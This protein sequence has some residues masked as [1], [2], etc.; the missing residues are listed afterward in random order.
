R[1]ARDEIAGSGGE[2]RS[3]VA[4]GPRSEGVTDPREQCQLA[5]AEQSQVSM[6]RSR[7]V[8]C[9]GS[10]ASLTAR[11]THARRTPNA[12]RRATLDS[13]TPPLANTAMLTAEGRAPPP[14]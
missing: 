8:A 7:R 5:I 1:A 11:I 13:S 14:P 9:S 2:Q 3:I 6:A 4:R 12:T 10:A